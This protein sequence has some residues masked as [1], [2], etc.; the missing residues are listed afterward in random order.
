MCSVIF[1]VTVKYYIVM[2][3]VLSILFSSYFRFCF[4]YQ[5]LS[6]RN[7]GITSYFIF[8]KPFV[9]ERTRHHQ[10]LCVMHMIPPP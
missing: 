2:P 3:L 9:C 4:Y 5:N 10:R 1:L 7:S 8:M 6:F